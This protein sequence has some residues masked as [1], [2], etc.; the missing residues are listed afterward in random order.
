MF[1][2]NFI[3]II[4]FFTINLYSFIL[5]ILN[6]FLKTYLKIIEEGFTD[7]L[8]PSAFDREREMPIILAMNLPTALIC[9]PLTEAWCK[10]H[11]HRRLDRQKYFFSSSHSPT[12]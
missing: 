2:K 4:S 9:Q 10:F 7:G 12:E 3:C 5:L 1:N 6:N 11:N 8:Y